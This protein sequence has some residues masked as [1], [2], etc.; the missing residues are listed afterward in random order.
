MGVTEAVTV[1]MA[2]VRRMVVMRRVVVVRHGPAYA[3]GRRRYT[4]TVSAPGSF[5]LLSQ[6]VIRGLD[7]RIFIRLAPDARVKPGHD[8]IECDYC[9]FRNLV[10]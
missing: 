10:R 5:P 2:W 6:V 9:S 3:A 7:P 4:I 8:E 1:V